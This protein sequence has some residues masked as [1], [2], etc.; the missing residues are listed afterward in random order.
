MIVWADLVTLYWHKIPT[1]Q[2]RKG[3]APLELGL[4]GDVPDVEE[5][6]IGGGGYFA[7]GFAGG[8]VEGGADFFLGGGEAREGDF[9]GGAG[10]QLIEIVEDGGD[11]EFVF[12]VASLGDVGLDHCFEVHGKGFRSRVG[13]GLAPASYSLN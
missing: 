8:A 12:A 4:V 5:G 3:G 13:H 10:L 9:E 2:K 11:D 7:A 6:G 1:L